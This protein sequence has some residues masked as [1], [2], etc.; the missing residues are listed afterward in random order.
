MVESGSKPPSREERKRCW[1]LRDQYF[2]CLD[3]CNIRDPAT[4]EKTPEKAPECLE[5]KKNY[6]EGCMASWVEYF[7]KR[8]VLDMRQ[9]EYLKFS[10]EQS[11]RK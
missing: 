3:R 9:K 8:R 4:V 7:N 6:E 10:E 5:L 1:F 2:Q 11:G